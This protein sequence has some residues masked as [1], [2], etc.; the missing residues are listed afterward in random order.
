[1]PQKDQKPQKKKEKQE[2]TRQET[3]KKTTQRP[4]IGE[5]MAALTTPEGFIMIS[6]AAFLDLIGLIL[7]VLSLFGVGIALSWGIDL[8]GLIFIGIWM[9]LRSGT[10]A[11]TK[12]GKKVAQKGLKR[13]GL[14]ALGEIVPF[15]GDI[16]PLWTWAVYS[17][18]KNS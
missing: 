15:L 14:A 10:I 11:A 13:F 17:E 8:V 5:G 12:G 6:F 18:L 9:F 1:M 2:G 4:P 7:F 16:A 3:S